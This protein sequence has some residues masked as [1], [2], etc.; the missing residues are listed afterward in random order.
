MRSRT[1]KFKALEAK[2]LQVI[3]VK[4]KHADRVALFHFL[5]A[6]EKILVSCFVGL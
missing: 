4:I 1:Q 3:Q 2:R 6:L 5:G